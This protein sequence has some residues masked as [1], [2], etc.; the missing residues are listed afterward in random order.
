MDSDSNHYIPDQLNAHIDTREFENELNELFGSLRSNELDD[1]NLWPDIYEN[2][3]SRI[4]SELSEPNEDDLI[5]RY[6]TPAKF[7]WFAHQ[8]TIY[9]GSAKNFEDRRD[10]DIPEDYNNSVQ[11]TLL[12]RDVIPLFWDDYLERMR[13]RWLVSCWTSLDNHHDDYLLWHRYAG[14]ELGVGIVITYGKLKTIL[15]TE[16]RKDEEVKLFQ[17]GR[18]GYKHPLHLPPFN[19]RNIF[20]NEKEIRFVCKTELLSSKS[21]DV[22]SL[23]ETFSL[24]FSPDAPRAHIDSVREVWKKIGGGSEYHISGD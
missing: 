10:S 6:F 19:K 13:S 4:N 15:E 24:R 7:L 3:I 22:S 1:A 21:I 8:N 2:I 11:K 23:K 5:C 16:C 17:C 9:F 14:S 20:R 12:E 18:V